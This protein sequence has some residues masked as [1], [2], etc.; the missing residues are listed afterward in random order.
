MFLNCPS[1]NKPMEVEVR[2]PV[3]QNFESVSQI[4]LEHAGQIACPACGKVCQPAMT[5][6]I[7]INVSLIPVPPE[8]QKQIVI[9][10]SSSKLPP[11]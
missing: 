3:V 10:A 1:C 8:K 4:L 5:P 7:N 9:P 6:P 11:S 2:Q